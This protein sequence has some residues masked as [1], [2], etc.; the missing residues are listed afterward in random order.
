[1][2]DLI[3]PSSKLANLSTPERTKFMKD[4]YDY[5]VQLA[6]KKRSFVADIPD[7]E[8]IEIENKEMARADAAVL[9]IQLLEAARKDLEK[10]KQSISSRALL[11]KS[12][13]IVSG[14]RSA[15]EQFGIWRKL[16]PKYYFRTMEDREK[17]EGGEHG[18]L[19]VKFAAEFIHGRLAAPGYS[20]HNSGIA[21]DFYTNERGVHLGANKDQVSPWLRS[22]FFDW[23]R[24]EASKFYFYQNKR[25]IEPWH[26]EFKAPRGIV[27]FS[28]EDTNVDVDKR[29][30]K[31]TMEQGDDYPVY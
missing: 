7:K 25:I 18:E 19:A 28:V 17:L 16:F 5:Q 26:W 8:L 20:L 15:T 22:W 13:G 29:K 6:G 23:M 3:I 31:C 30:T 27:L 10:A 14:Y 12:I 1:M 21:V 9:C 2:T 11:V 4:V 24:A